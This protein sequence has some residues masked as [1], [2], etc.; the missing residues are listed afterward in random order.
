MEKKTDFM[1]TLKRQQFPNFFLWYLHARIQSQP[2]IRHV[3]SMHI[4]LHE[5]PFISGLMS[6]RRKGASMSKREWKKFPG[7]MFVSFFIF[8][9]SVTKRSQQLGRHLKS[10]KKNDLWREELCSNFAYFSIFWSLDPGG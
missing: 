2:D 9:Y 6:G 3:H 1:V 10:E 7:C 4:D 5:E 8:S